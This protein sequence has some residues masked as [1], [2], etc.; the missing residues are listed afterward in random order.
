MASNHRACRAERAK[1]WGTLCATLAVYGSVGCTEPKSDSKPVATV[2]PLPAQSQAQGKQGAAPSAA[3]HATAGRETQ[4]K[5]DD[6]KVGQSVGS[7]TMKPD[8]TIV[9]QLRATGPGGMVGD[10]VVEY[11]PSHPNY[12]EVLQ[13]L[14]GLEPGQEKLVPPWPE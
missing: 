6:V 2:A 12:A 11:P 8:R 10:S 13:H 4:G 1:L 14:G 7:A 5:A 3:A 9:L